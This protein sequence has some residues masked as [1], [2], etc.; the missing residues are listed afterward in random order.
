MV[1]VDLA[2]A[3]YH[4]PIYA[5]DH[6][7]FVFRFCGVLDQVNVLPMGWLNPLAAVGGGHRRL[8]PPFPPHRFYPPVW[9][10]RPVRLGAHVLPYLDDFLF[11]FTSEEQ[12]RVGA[13]WVTESIEILGLSCD[14]TKCQWM[15]SQSVYHLG[16][17]VNMADDLFEVPGEKVAKLWRLAVGMHVTA[18]KSHHLVQKR[19]L[20]KLCGFAQSVKLDLIPAPLFLCNS[21][22]AL[23]QPVGWSGK[24]RLSQGSM[25][26]L[27]WRV[28]VPARHCSAAIHLGTTVVELSMDASRH[29]WGAVLHGRTACGYWSCAEVPAHIN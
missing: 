17:T 4:I 11:V 3:F 6:C 18:K 8:A 21:Y 13:Q 22:D 27:N 10:G 24:V 28:K 19:E 26:D 2:S 29:P 20:A 16:I 1:K 23:A 7:F 15:L 5:V 9:C 12:A 14:S 25:R